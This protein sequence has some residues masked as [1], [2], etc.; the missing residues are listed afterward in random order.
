MKTLIILLL[1]SPY[2]YAQMGTKDELTAATKGLADQQA[3]TKRHQEALEREQK[4]LKDKQESL[5]AIKRL[6][7]N[8]REVKDEVMAQIEEHRSGRNRSFY[9]CLQKS[10]EK[11]GHVT[12]DICQREKHPRLSD[13]EKAL[14]EGW[15][16]AI[17]IPQSQIKIEMFNLEKKVD[18]L[19]GTVSRLEGFVKSSQNYE[20][21][22]SSRIALIEGRIQE[23]EELKKNPQYLNCDENTPTINLEEKVPFPGATFEGP[24]FGIPRDNQD[25]IGSCFANTA[26]NLL[27][28]LSEGKEIASFLDMALQ[29]KIDSGEVIRDGL[30]GGMSCITLNKIAKNG[31][32]PQKY[33][34]IE[35]ADHNMLVEGLFNMGQYEYMATNI[36]MMKN[37][38]TGVDSFKNGKGPLK[39]ET[40][41][42]AYDIVQKLKNNPDVI[43]PMPVARLEIPSRWKLKE[44]YHLNK[45]RIG[46]EEKEF[47][48]Q[49][50]AEYQNKFFPKY[51]KGLL[52]GKNA[53]QIFDIYQES[54]KDFIADNGMSSM[55]E[56]A[57]T[58]F[59][60][61]SNVDFKDP[62][63]KQ[64]LR[65]SAN[66]LK[67]IFGLK[68]DDD[69]KLIEYCAQ[70]G[71]ENFKLL[72]VMEPVLRAINDKKIN[73]DKLFDKDG[74]LLNPEEL[75]QL[76][77]APACLH[78]SNRVK[79]DF[80]FNCDSGYATINQIRA[81]NKSE[82]EKIKDFRERVLLSL[83][84]GYPLGNSHPT[85]PNSAHINTIAGIRFNKE[86]KRCEYLIRESQNG[87]SEWEVEADIF[88]NISALTEVRRK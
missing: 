52:E 50:D 79:L 56:Q 39:E 77:I 76:T 66:F 73:G 14:V 68:E 22:A 21:D 41:A 85:G 59:I 83:M 88:K 44:F 84:K 82:S 32:C 81:S 40:L 55:M 70:E 30:D 29:Y 62:K 33:A 54:M 60:S 38:I 5:D 8:P 11:K 65:A 37:F 86:L 31:Y 63:F 12:R 1:L 6:A 47:L 28:G 87:Q 24:F 7:F 15:H 35:N 27:V 75:M 4:V 23:R 34:P 10:I 26:K 16:K 9:K 57:R 20:L 80:E 48:T 2:A 45:L 72:A 42:R 67:D 61:D 19:T 49:Y 17:G 69:A 18:D 58:M 46:K 51:L 13:E 25:G 78:P 43:I 36:N 53:N 64:K 74:K 3:I 71:N